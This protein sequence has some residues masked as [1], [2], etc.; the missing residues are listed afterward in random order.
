M[1]VFRTAA[2]VIIIIIVVTMIVMILSICLLGYRSFKDTSSVKWFLKSPGSM[3]T[4]A[5]SRKPAAQGRGSHR[6]P[7]LP[8][9]GCSVN[10]A[11]LGCFCCAGCLRSLSSTPQLELSKEPRLA[12]IST[13]PTG[14]G[15]PA[16]R[17]RKQVVLPGRL[18]FC[19]FLRFHLCPG[20]NSLEEIVQF[21]VHRVG[22]EGGKEKSPSLVSHLLK[23]T[24]N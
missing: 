5:G 14:F 10:A 16:S 6:G 7:H 22:C 23:P 20:P 15:Q 24:K 12:A 8:S 13:E 11:L 17:G 2:S 19:S 4:F 3:E 1:L 18:I 9:H 21:R